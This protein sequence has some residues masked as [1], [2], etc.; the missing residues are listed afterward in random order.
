MATAVNLE[1]QAIANLRVQWE[2]G[3]QKRRVITPEAGRA[4]ELLGHAIEYLTDEYVGETKNLSPTD[5]QVAAILLLMDLNRK[6]YFGC[7]IRL[8]V[9]E[10]IRAF[11]YGTE[12]P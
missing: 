6:V 2:T 12:L 1:V 8:T 5:P 7:P 3:R 4:L 9:G 10:R 11:L